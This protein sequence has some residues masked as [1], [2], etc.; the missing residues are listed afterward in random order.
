MASDDLLK[1]LEGIGKPDEKKEKEITS[2]ETFLITFRMWESLL[3]EI[4]PQVHHEGQ[5][6]YDSL[7]R[8]EKEGEQILTPYKELLPAQIEDT[9][10]FMPIRFMEP[11]YKLYAGLFY[12]ALLNTGCTST[13]KVP[14]DVPR[15]CWGYK[16]RKGTLNILNGVQ[17]TGEQMSGGYLEVRGKMHWHVGYLATGGVCVTDGEAPSLGT[18]ATGGI[19]INNGHVSFGLGHAAVNGVFINTG[20]ISSAFGSGAHEGFFVNYGIHKDSIG[21]GAEKAIVV[22]RKSRDRTMDEHIIY[23]A[24]KDLKGSMLDKMLDELLAAIKIK[25][26]AK[27]QQILPNVRE[28]A[29][30]FWV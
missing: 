19:F 3:E 9:P 24:D 14:E 13:I 30:Y 11:G 23:I 17:H 26:I 1:Q 18:F 28:T 22:D 15:S 21:F 20:Y 16:L 7:N 10:Y 2:L 29:M 5:I 12:T 25:D 27:V 8:L 6:S 4:A